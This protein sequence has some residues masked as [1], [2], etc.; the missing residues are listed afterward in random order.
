MEAAGVQLAED[1]GLAI[2]VKGGRLRAVDASNLIIE[3]PQPLADSSTPFTALDVYRALHARAR[4]IAGAHRD[5][6]RDG[7]A[8]VAHFE[9]SVFESI[10]ESF[11]EAPQAAAGVP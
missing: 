8:D 5:A 4:L 7:A 9:G 6:N 11:L 1:L 10:H 2:L 3:V